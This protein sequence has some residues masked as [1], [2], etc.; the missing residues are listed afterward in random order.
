M[1]MAP[2]SASRFDDDAG[3]PEPRGTRQLELFGH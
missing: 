3:D 2:G 1:E